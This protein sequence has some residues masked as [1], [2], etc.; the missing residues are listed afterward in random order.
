MS[1]DTDSRSWF[2]AGVDIM[3]E[4]SSNEE[5]SIEISTGWRA[6]QDQAFGDCIGR[7]LEAQRSVRGLIT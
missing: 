1:C 2:S 3:G 4:F 7:C 5:E 6:V